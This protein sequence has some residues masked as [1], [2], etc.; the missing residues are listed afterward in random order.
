MQSKCRDDRPSL[1]GSDCCRSDD[2][3][4]ERLCRRAEEIMTLFS[5]KPHLICVLSRHKGI[6]SPL[7]QKTMIPFTVPVLNVSA[8]ERASLSSFV[9]G[10][11]GF[12]MGFLTPQPLMDAGVVAGMAIGFSVALGVRLVVERSL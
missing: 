6:I 1:H 4:L 3:R 2:H 12:G 7:E 11:L 10:L 8:Q 5:Q 9:G